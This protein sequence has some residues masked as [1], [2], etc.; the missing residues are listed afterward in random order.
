METLKKK[1]RHSAKGCEL[2]YLF[3]LFTLFVK[4]YNWPILTHI[5][6][7]LWVISRVKIILDNLN[8]ELSF[9]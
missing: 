2:Y 9:K 5:F 1:N 4:E 6:I 7:G 8:E 3:T